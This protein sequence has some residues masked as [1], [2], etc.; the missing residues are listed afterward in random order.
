VLWDLSWNQTCDKLDMAKSLDISGW[1]FRLDDEPEE[2]FMCKPEDDSDNK[3]EVDPPLDSAMLKL[4]ARAF[5]ELEKANA[6]T[7]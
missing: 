1:L 2:I 4:A 3:P 7:A 6:D 5:H